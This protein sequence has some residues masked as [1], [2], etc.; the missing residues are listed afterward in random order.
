MHS[1]HARRAAPIPALNAEQQSELR[2]D[3]KAELRRLVPDAEQLNERGLRDLAPRARSR[4]TQ[5]VNVLRRM[6]TE[7]FGVCVS[8]RSP[9]AY[10]RLSAIPET[11]VCAPCSWRYEVSLQG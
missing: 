11:T 3:L 5:I 10:E 7:N 2:S 4:A 6:G 8:C 9:I 1:A